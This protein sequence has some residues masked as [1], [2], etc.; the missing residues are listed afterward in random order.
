MVSPEGPMTGDRS[1]L[2]FDSVSEAETDRLGRSL[3]A[4]L[5]PG[6]VI[7]L[8]GP[9]GAGKTRLVRAI[10]EALGADPGA[11]GSPTFVL[12]HE[13]AARM[14][15]YHFDAYRLRSPE[16]FEA[17][18]VDEYFAGDGVCLIEWADRVGELTPESTWWI[19]AEP[20]EA[21]RRYRLRLP[22]LSADRL[23]SIWGRS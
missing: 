20:R 3:S 17:L 5:T 2:V 19:S 6:T 13:Y 11:I 16:E 22:P 7:G 4:V 9:L 15:V 12:I 14:P 21:G 1:E 18:G 10:A 23:R 8:I